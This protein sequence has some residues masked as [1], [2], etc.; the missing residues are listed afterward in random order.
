MLEANTLQTTGLP[1]E[2]GPNNGKIRVKL[3]CP[4]FE[5][6]TVEADKVLLP[7]QNGDFLI[8]PERAPIF[9]SLKAGRMI[10]YNE[11]KE[12]LSYLI[13]R[14][15]CE[16]RRNLCPVLAWGGK[17]DKIDPRI[18]AGHLKEAER[19]MKEVV[20]SI[21]KHEVIARVEFFKNVLQELNYIPDG[22]ETSLDMKFDVQK[23]KEVL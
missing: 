10:I 15:I 13:S 14:G 11:G 22:T 18:I 23:L 17:E 6:I 9:I 5:V 20:S 4:L 16:I 2:P 19:A 3:I 21:E 1:A 8:L 12:P 7:A